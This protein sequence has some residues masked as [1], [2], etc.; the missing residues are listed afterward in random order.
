MKELGLRHTHL[1]GACADCHSLPELPTVS[2]N[3]MEL[4]ADS[5]EM[6]KRYRTY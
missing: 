2:D 1:C 6:E 3:E 4:N 5:A